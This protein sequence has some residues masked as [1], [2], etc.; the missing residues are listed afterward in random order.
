MAARRT[1]LSRSSAQFE[2]FDLGVCVIVLLAI[3][4]ALDLT[5]M[6]GTDLLKKLENVKLFRT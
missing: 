1:D 2:G 6:F 5:N 4:C 3:F